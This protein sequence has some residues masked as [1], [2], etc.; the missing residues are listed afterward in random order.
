VVKIRMASRR[1]ASLVIAAS[2][3]WTIQKI[4]GL[5]II[6]T[7]M[8]YI[9][10]D[11]NC[12]KKLSISAGGDRKKLRRLSRMLRHFF[13]KTYTHLIDQFPSVPFAS[14]RDL[15]V[16]LGRNSNGRLFRESTAVRR[17]SGIA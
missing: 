6:L 7:R 13:S 11:F 2:G 3:D 9:E 16:L 15:G 10:T 1:R 8:A 4:R 14:W 5:V 12:V 17:F